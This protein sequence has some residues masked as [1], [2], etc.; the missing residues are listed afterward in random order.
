[1]ILAEEQR[2]LVPADP[3]DGFASNH[4]ELALL[5]SADLLVAA[6]DVGGAYAP[7]RAQVHYLV[8]VYNILHSA[9][10]KV[11]DG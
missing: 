6:G 10:V 1:M 7:G 8:K 3:F 11:M 5:F 9:K 2:H 4:V